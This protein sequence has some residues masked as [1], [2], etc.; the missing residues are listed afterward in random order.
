LVA[1]TVAYVAMGF[2]WNGDTSY[3]LIAVQLA[4]LGAGFGLTVA[5]TNAAVIAGAAPDQRGAAAGL[6]MVTRLLGFSVGLSALTAWGLA[7]FNSLR[8]NID[9]PP[10][11]D[12]GFESALRDASEQLTSKAI[13]ET[14]LATAAVTVI[15]LGAALAM[16][17]QPRPERADVPTEQ[18]SPDRPIEQTGVAMP[19]WL[20]RH[21]GLVL[22]AFALLLIGAFVWIAILMSQVHDTRRDLDRVEAGAAIFASQVQGFQSKISDLAPNVSAGLDEAITGLESFGNSTVEFSV[23]ID[24]N[25]Q[26]DT[27]VVIDRDI[28]VPIKTTLPIKESFDTTIKVAGPFGIDI[29]LDVTVPVDINVPIDLKVT[30]P[31]HETIP[32]DANVPVK[33]DVPI[34]VDVSETQLAE[35][36]KALAAGLRSFQEVLTGLGG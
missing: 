21:L 13:A 18:P 26:F 30:V 17:R 31:I 25:V 15:G 16:R 5:P 8:G 20:N 4:V 11:T 36:A 24:E 22:G 2:T 35:L 27:D 19:S 12:P 1:A 23:P 7:R 33:L 29:P 10:I 28:V 6:V 3:L 32:I 34:S 9:L 14:F